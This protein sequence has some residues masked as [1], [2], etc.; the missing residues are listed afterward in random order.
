MYYKYPPVYKYI[1]LLI[2]ITT[3]LK[4]Y[5]VITKENYLLIASI[6]AYMVFVFDYVLIEEHPNLFEEKMDI[7]EKTMDKKDKKNKKRKDKKK[8]CKKIRI[9][10]DIKKTEENIEH[11]ADSIEEK[12][13]D[14]M[15]DMDDLD[16]E[17]IEFDKSLNSK[18]NLNNNETDTDDNLTE[19]IQKELD[20]LDL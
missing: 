6:F 16:K 12:D 13:M 7:D 18:N 17:L 10:N 4:Y 14:D 9:I 11:F 3:F 5:K 2:L 20:E 1:I 19:E 8:E 15:D